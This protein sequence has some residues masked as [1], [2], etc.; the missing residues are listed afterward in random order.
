[1]RVHKLLVTLAVSPFCRRIDGEPVETDL[2]RIGILGGAI[3][4]LV[5]WWGGRSSEPTHP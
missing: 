2:A 5:G 1:M 4:G 3:N